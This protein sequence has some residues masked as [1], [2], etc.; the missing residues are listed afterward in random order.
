MKKFN[1]QFF[2]S[3][4]TLSL[5]KITLLEDYEKM[6][7]IRNFELRLEACYQQGKIGGF[8]HSYIGQEAIQT[9]C[10]RAIGL[11]SWYTT[12]YRCHAL[13]LLHKISLKDIFAELFG[14]ITGN[15]KGRGGSM[16]L[17]SDKMLGGFAIVGGHA[18]IAAGAAF[19]LAYKNVKDKVSICFLGEGAT[20][21]GAFHESLNIASLWNLPC[22]YV[23]EN[24]QWGMGTAASKAVSIQPIAKNMSVAYNMKSYTLDGM[25]YFE[26]FD[27]F[28]HIFEETK[29]DQRPVLVEVVTERFKGH[30]ISDPG[31]Y[32]SKEELEIAKK[33]DPIHLFKNELIKKNFLSEEDAIQIEKK[34]IEIIKNA[35]NEAEKDSDPDPVILG[36]DVFAPEDEKIFGA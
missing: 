27:G 16:H 10:V 20:P 19:S 2:K 9:A 3:D 24:N 4:T 12:T 1:Y 31:F 5:D 32:R 14:K 15:A 22:I 33:R 17:Y 34:Q 21:Q 23:I 8:M 36:E 6:V 26:L 30:S 11:D 7:L 29:N 28:L 35:M 25:D 18:P 13:A